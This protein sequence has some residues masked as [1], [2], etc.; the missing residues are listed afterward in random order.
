VK[1]TRSGCGPA[2]DPA[3]KAQ[4][5]PTG[6]QRGQEKR[7]GPAGRLAARAGEEPRASRQAGSA[8]R[9]GADGRRPGRCAAA[10]G[11]R[12]GSRVAGRNVLQQ[13]RDQDGER[14]LEMRWCRPGRAGL[15]MP[16]PALG[17]LWRAV[18]AER[19]VGSESGVLKQRASRAEKFKREH[20]GQAT[21]S[22]SIVGV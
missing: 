18:S 20:D 10:T 22:C 11:R 21:E 14:E 2:R 16:T 13:V 17:T 1:E 4:G 3:R 12:A 9:I 6:W 15:K 5:Q 8:S 7:A 19:R